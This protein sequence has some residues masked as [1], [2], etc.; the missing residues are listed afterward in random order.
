MA[1][2]DQGT[3]STRVILYDVSEGA[4]VP[5]P[6]GSHQ[7][8]LAGAT[9]HPHAGWAQMDARAI[10]DSVEAC[11]AG[12]LAGADA[13]VD[14][15]VGVGITNQRE[16]TVVW[17]KETGEPLCSV[18]LWLDARTRDTV[19]ELE[20]ENGGKDA[21]RSIC[22]LPLSTYFS[23][24][25][26]RWML[27][28]DAEVRDALANGRALLGTVDSWVVWNLTRGERHVTDVSNAS[29]TM[30]MDLARCEWSE[31]ALR[32]LGL[33]GQTGVKDALPSIVASAGDL[34]RVSNGGALD[35]V[36]ITG[37]IGDQQGAM[38]GQRCFSPGMAKSTYGTGAF[39][40]MNTGTSPVASN[41]G[42]LSTAL[43]RIGDDAETVYALEGAIGACAVGI[44]WFRDSLGMIESAPE[45]DVLAAEARNGT[46]GL[47]FVSAFGGLLAPHWRDDARAALVGLSLAHK[48]PH[49]ARAVLEGIAF[50]VRD[51]C[52]AM[53]SDAANE[54]TE[55]RVDG[56]VCRSD[57]ML[58]YQ[59]DFLGV[60]VARPKNVETTA[61]GAALLAGVGAGALDP[62][63]GDASADDEGNGRDD[64]T[65]FEP[66][67]SDA[68]RAA[69]LESWNDAVNS[70]L[71]WADRA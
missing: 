45:I 18:V 71:G 11:A 38:V 70:S 47:Y 36:P 64:L 35:G 61:L 7:V 55:L 69:R 34:G 50:Q 68:E 5:V 30:L 54:L 51:V 60:G 37:I 6:G 32:A 23:G 3:S 53:A 63:R 31:D 44:N 24:V 41:H 2:I 67:I 19:A 39:V 29:R 40:L 8:E 66:Q 20:R 12:A 17:D 4:P 52:E 14:E 43:Y 28:N 26:L 42:L 22:G 33:R 59:A 21:L 16:S 46:E 57:E 58:Q 62:P 56:G 9:T 27:D 10:V 48:R 25:K 1:A 65:R 49:V 15:V 13:S